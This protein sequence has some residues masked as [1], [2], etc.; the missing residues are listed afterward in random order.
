[1]VPAAIEPGKAPARCTV[2]AI[3]LLAVSKPARTDRSFAE[4]LP[5]L[6]LERGLS[7]RALARSIAI[8]QSHLS[9]LS[10]PNARQL[11]SRSVSAAVAVALGLPTDYF[12]EYRRATVIEAIDRDAALRERFYAHVKA[13]R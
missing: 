12:A 5:R 13:R 8:N 1:M 7:Q 10:G 2:R 11:P 6:L 3:E 4:E 9:R